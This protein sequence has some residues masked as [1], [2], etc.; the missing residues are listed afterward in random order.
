MNDAELE[1]VRNLC[2]Q[3]IHE[4]DAYANG[5]DRED[6]IKAAEELRDEISFS[7]LDFMDD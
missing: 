2:V 4:Y 1:I 5:D 7:A 6:V 3:Y